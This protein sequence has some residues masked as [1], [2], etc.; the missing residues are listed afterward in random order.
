MAPGVLLACVGLVGVVLAVLGVFSAFASLAIGAPLAALSVV[1]VRRALPPRRGGGDRAAIAAVALAL[2]FVLA[3][4]WAPSTHVLV[5]R[6]PGSYTTT[7]RWLDRAGGL[8]VDAAAGGL[9]AEDPVGFGGYAVHDLG[10][11]RLQFQFNHLTSVALAVGFGVGGEWLMFRVP[12]VVGAAGLL[13]LYA[14]AVRALGRRWVALIAPGLIAVSMPFLYVARDT[15]SEAFTL[16]LLWTALLVGLVAVRSG[17]LGAAAVSGLLLGATA[18]SRIDA[19]LYAAIA[20]PLL[21]AHVVTGRADPAVVRRRGRVAAAV[22]AA[23]VLAA[24]PGVADL[25]LRSGRYS[26]NHA[27]EISQLRVLAGASLVVSAALVLVLLRWP[28]VVDRLR[29]ASRRLAVPAA[30]AMVVS[31]LA[32]WWI[33]PHVQVARSDRTVALTASL[34]SAAGVEVDGSRQYAELSM[35]WMSWYLGPLGLLLGLVGAGLAVRLILRGRAR[36]GLVAVTALLAV[37]GGLYW[38]RPSIVPDQVWAMRRYVPAVLPALAMSAGLAVAALS[39][40]RSRLAAASTVR[41]RAALALAVSAVAVVW[42]AAVTWPVRQLR[43]QHGYVEVV[44]EACDLIGPDSTVLVVGEPS[45]H[46]L[47]QPLRSWCGAPVGSLVGAPTP[48]AL[49][50]VRADVAEAGRTLTWVSSDP[51]RIAAVAADGETTV[52][53]V[54]REERQARRTLLRAPSEYSDPGGGWSLTVHRESPR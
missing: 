42:A 26:S 14:V 17:R 5:N 45:I 2:L 6:D 27:E 40:G 11:G 9:R 51:A 23:T 52:T 38:W 46:V 47:A 54:V 28:A 48:E 1:A 31:G 49:A 22:V 39:G 53:R 44:L 32:A 4:S 33:R 24:L 34:Q 15:Y 20:F 18:S 37:A 12:A 8:E 10:E 7:A 36:P 35:Q 25:H 3:A 29:V 43:E 50:R 30:A 19:L 41:T 21:A 16:L 13:V